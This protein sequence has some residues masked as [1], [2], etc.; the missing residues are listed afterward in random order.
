MLILSTALVIDVLVRL[1]VLKQEPHQYLDVWLIWAATTL[2]VIIGTT[3]SGVEPFGARSRSWVAIAAGAV[4]A[5]T[6][7]AALMGT[8]ASLADL[9]TWIAGSLAGVFLALV[10]M[11]GV[12]GA[13]ERRTLGRA[14]RE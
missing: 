5:N 7:V 13:W 11:R 10:I 4:V 9:I 8:L 1:L 3:A 14:S 12:Y 2:Y 6:A